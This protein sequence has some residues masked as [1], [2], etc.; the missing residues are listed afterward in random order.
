MAVNKEEQSEIFGEGKPGRD[1]ACVLKPSCEKGDRDMSVMGGCDLPHA[2]TQ[3]RFLNYC[4]APTVGSLYEINV[5]NI[6]F[7]LLFF[8]LSEIS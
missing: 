7:L 6:T 4:A 5:Q 3:R 2:H 8:I 1:P